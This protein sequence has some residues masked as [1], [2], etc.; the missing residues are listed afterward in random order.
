MLTLSIT[1]NYDGYVNSLSTRGSNLVLWDTLYNVYLLK[2]MTNL[3]VCTAKPVLR[4]RN[5]LS[6][7]L[8]YLIK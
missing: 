5:Q 4:L 2:E 8:K 1:I 3:K 6:T 7:A